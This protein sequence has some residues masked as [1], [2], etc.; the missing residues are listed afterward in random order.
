MSSDTGLERRLRDFLPWPRL[1]PPR[2]VEDVPK[3]LVVP[4]DANRAD[5]QEAFALLSVMQQEGYDL[6]RKL[7]LAAVVEFG[8]RRDRAYRAVEAMAGSGWDS[9]LYG[10]SSGWVVRLTSTRRVGHEVLLE[11]IS[12]MKRLAATT[13]GRVRGLTVEDLRTE[14]HWERMAAQLRD[15]GTHES[16]RPLVPTQRPP[17]PDAVGQGSGALRR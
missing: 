2:I 11:A 4:L 16:E 17:L 15:A 1:V 9:A 12:A 10:D 7:F 6:R 8:P 13:D 5:E 14:D 3:Q